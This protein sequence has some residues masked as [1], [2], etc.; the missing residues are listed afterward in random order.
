MRGDNRAV[1]IKAD[2]II[3][4]LERLIEE[5]RPTEDTD[6]IRRL[7]EEIRDEARRATGGQP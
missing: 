4:A 3:R 7:A 5:H 1:A 6:T 2:F